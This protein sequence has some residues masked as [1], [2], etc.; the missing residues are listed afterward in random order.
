MLAA[1]TNLTGFEKP[2]LPSKKLAKLSYIGNINTYGDIPEFLGGL[3]N[4]SVLH[5]EDNS[6]NGSV[7]GKTLRRHLLVHVLASHVDSLTLLT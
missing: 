6:F 2:W 5:L 1:S 4:L 7:P 3:T